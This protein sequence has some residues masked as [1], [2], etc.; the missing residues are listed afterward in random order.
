MR[1][2]E[3]TAEEKLARRRLSL[4]QVAEA[5]GN[6]SVPSRLRGVSRSQFDAY[7]RR[8]QKHRLKGLKDLPPIPKPDLMTTAPRVMERLLE[9]SLEHP[10]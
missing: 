2:C 4:I 1:R 9:R 8:V 10:A 7:K 5:L 6:A 3:M